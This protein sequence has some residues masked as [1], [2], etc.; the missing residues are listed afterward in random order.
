MS[1]CR[2]GRQSSSGRS[3]SPTAKASRVIFTW[4]WTRRFSGSR[5]ASRWRP[6]SC[7]ACSLRSLPRVRIPRTSSRAVRQA[8]GARARFEL[9]AMQIALTSIAAQRRRAAVAELQPSAARPAIRGGARR[10]LSRSPGCGAIRLRSEE[11]VRTVAERVSA[12]PGVEHVAF[13]RGAGFTWSTSPEELGAGASAG[14]SAQRC[15]SAL[16]FAGLF[17]RRCRSRCSLV[18]FS[19]ADAAGTPLVAIVDESMAQRLFGGRGVSARP[20]TPAARRF[21]SSASFRITASARRSR[22]RCRWPSSLF[23]RTPSNPSAMHVSPYASPA[24]RRGCSRSFA[25]PCARSIRMCP[26]RN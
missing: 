6:R 13:A 3:S 1:R 2:Y 9:I 23:G 14:D 15:R 11:Y 22:P 18:E 16:R 26:W 4:G 19:N 21:G 12:L 20:C 8:A 24:I 7:S 25:R 17:L 10:G 5:S